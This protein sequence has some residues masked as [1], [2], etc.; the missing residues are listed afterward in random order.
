MASFDNIFASP[1]SEQQHPKVPAWSVSLRRW[2]SASISLV[3]DVPVQVA[4]PQVKHSEMFKLLETTAEK[5]SGLVRN[6]RR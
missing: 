6:K 1:S 2:V 3:F 5:I 4:V